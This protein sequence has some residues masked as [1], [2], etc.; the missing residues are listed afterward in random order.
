MHYIFDENYSPKLANGLSILEEGNSRSPFKV[1]VSHLTDLA[2]KMGTQDEEVIVIAG[3]NKGIIITQDS[4]F[5]RIKHY[6]QLYKEHKVGAVYFKSTNSKQS[7]WG[8][9]EIFV[10]RWEELKLH[11]SRS[12]APFVIEIHSKGISPRHF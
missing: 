4:D 1:R 11:V 8:T 5:K 2:G 9:I 10:N 12:K 7:Y 6:H 3:K